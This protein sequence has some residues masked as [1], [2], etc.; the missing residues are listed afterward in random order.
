MAATAAAVP[1][2]NGLVDHYSATNP[3]SDHDE[4]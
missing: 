4:A 3:D 2:S 1:P